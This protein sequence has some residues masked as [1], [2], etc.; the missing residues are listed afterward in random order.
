M[1]T[2]GSSSLQGAPRLSSRRVRNL[3]Y[4]YTKK[5]GEKVLRQTEQAGSQ[6]WLPLPLMLPVTMSG[7]P[8][9]PVTAAAAL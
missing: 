3:V 5:A 2:A 6:E 7:V 8:L 4:R 9:M 1:D